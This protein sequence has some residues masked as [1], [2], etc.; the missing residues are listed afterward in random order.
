MKLIIFVLLFLANDINTSAS[1]KLYDYISQRKLIFIPG[2]LLVVALFVVGITLGVL[3]SE[4]KSKLILGNSEES[5]K[6][7]PIDST[8]GIH[9]LNIAKYKVQQAQI[10]YCNIYRKKISECLYV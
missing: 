8:I 9:F 2:A 7:I 6:N 5:R 3:E 4:D 10:N 1:S